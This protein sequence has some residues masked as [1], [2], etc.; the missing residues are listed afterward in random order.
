M[1]HSNA[2]RKWGHHGEELL[3][4]IIKLMGFRILGKVDSCDVC[5]AEKVKAK[6][7]ST[8]SDSSK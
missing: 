6:P 2:H 1:Q 5:I 7:I 8:T 4:I 3:K